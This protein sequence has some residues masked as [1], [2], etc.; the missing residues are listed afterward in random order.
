[1]TYFYFIVGLLSFSP[2]F[3][4]QDGLSEIHSG[5]YFTTFCA[6]VLNTQGE[7]E[8]QL[9]K[10]DFLLTL[11][12]KEVSIT[13]CRWV[14]GDQ[15]TFY[16]IPPKQESLHSVSVT[17]LEGNTNHEGPLEDWVWY[18]KPE[19]AKKE[20]LVFGQDPPSEHS[21]GR[22][23]VFLTESTPGL[24][25]SKKGHET[26]IDGIFRTF[27]PNDYVAI[28]QFGLGL[29]VKSDFTQNHQDLLLVLE[30]SRKPSND[31]TKCPISLVNTLN[32]SSSPNQ[33]SAAQALFLICDTLK[34]IHAQKT[35]L[36]F[37]QQSALIQA[38]MFLVKLEEQPFLKLF[39]E[40]NNAQIHV[41]SVCTANGSPQID[42][43]MRNDGSLS[44]CTGGLFIPKGNRTR[45]KMF[46]GM[47]A[48][49][50]E[51]TYSSDFDIQGKTAFSL[52]HPEGKRVLV[53]APYNGFGAF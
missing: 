42:H 1:M 17:R 24:G 15:S 39:M 36:M 27:S 26:L 33:K 32:E 6:H 18:T 52:R 7:S 22:F 38:E 35:V 46:L 29:K 23:F 19:I 13:D 50:Y 28:V 5:S 16:V 11:D 34:K 45:E 20:F 48:G 40:F 47:M 44:Q 41:S 9:E 12:G 2:L 37:G 30:G 10:E 53:Q 8:L 4:A 3:K 25:F 49:H 21:L 51:L 31:V 43:E 14:P